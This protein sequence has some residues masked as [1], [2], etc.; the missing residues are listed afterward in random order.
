M[1]LPVT[2][3]EYV[4]YM[5]TLDVDEAAT[6]ALLNA[7]IRAGDH[8]LVTSHARPDGDAVGSVLAFGELLRALGKRADLLLADPV[9]SVYRA[10]PGVHRIRQAS[11]VHPSQYDG[12]II[13][14]CDSTSRTGLDGWGDLPLINIDHHV[15]GSHYGG[16]NW[17][18]ANAC[19]VAAMVYR[20]S[21]AM[22]V[23]VSPEMATCL[24]AAVLTDTGAFT[25]PGTS[26]DTFT[27]AH[28]LIRRGAQADAV[29]RDVLYSQPP[30]RLQLLGLALS[31]M[32]TE[33]AVAW[34]YITQAD[35]ETHNATDEDTEGTVNYL[36]SMAGMEAAL[37]LRELPGLPVRYRISLRSKS[38]LDVSSVAALHSG[39]GHRN[40]AGCTVDGPYDAALQRVLGDL[41]NESRRFA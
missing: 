21:L 29:A 1:I 24:Y 12:A 30:A 15:T 20:A 16:L 33:E 32:R 38:S 28:D 37:F 22:G 11:T 2:D 27:L 41:Q 18:D 35:L 8:F 14:E 6:L 36:I 26:A 3:P 9:P 34:S 10:L 25:Y 4:P 31:R 23:P 5:Q 40:A 19:A 7:Q 13:L 17:I 39:G